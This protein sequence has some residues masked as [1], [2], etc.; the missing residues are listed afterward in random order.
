MG[1]GRVGLLVAVALVAAGCGGGGKDEKAAPAAGKV[2]RGE[3]ETG[4]K[5]RVQTFVAPSADP[6]LSKLDK[7][8]VEAGYPPVDFDLP[9]TLWLVPL[10]R[11]VAFTALRVAAPERL[12]LR[13]RP[14]APAEQ[15]RATRAARWCC[16]PRGM[17][18]DRPR[19]GRAHGSRAASA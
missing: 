13:V 5:L 11:D 6:E 17:D 3:T 9:R 2:V 19:S 12:A 16:R 4:M 1:P 14:V 15:A 10:G 7:Y 8:R 18:V